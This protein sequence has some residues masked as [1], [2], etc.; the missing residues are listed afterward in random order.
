MIE[1]F[2]QTAELDMT[3]CNAE[4]LVDY[5]D[6]FIGSGKKPT[7]TSSSKAAAAE[8]E[9][10]DPFDDMMDEAQQKEEEADQPNLGLLP[11]SVKSTQG[12]AEGPLQQKSGAYR[13]QS[14]NYSKYQTQHSNKPYQAYKSQAAAN[15]AAYD[16]DEDEDP[17][18]NDFDP[19]KETGNFFGREIP[20]EVKLRE[21]LEAQKARWGGTVTRSAVIDEEDEFDAMMEEDMGL[22]AP[23]AS[24]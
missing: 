11:E 15:F 16:E 9:E 23:S 3:V 19:E 24:K 8:D 21:E 1:K 4:L 13:G 22:R 10:R 12:K 20:E 7:F 6:L 2:R 17:A 14:G 5:C 18:W